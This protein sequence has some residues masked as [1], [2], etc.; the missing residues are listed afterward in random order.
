MTDTFT[1]SAWLNK[2]G[3]FLKRHI[4]WVGHTD[5]EASIPQ[6]R[7][8]NMQLLEETKEALAEIFTIYFNKCLY[9]R[10]ALFKQFFSISE[11]WELVNRSQWIINTESM[12]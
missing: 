7:Y 11:W 12:F 2:E 6:C 8:V 5:G 4:F 9:G 1:L 3:Q 10:A